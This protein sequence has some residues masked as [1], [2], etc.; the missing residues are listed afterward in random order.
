MTGRE[1]M[2]LA[3][4]L[5][6]GG[7]AMMILRRTETEVALPP[8]FTISPGGEVGGGPGGGGEKPGGGRA[9]MGDLI[10]ATFSEEGG[11]F[12]ASLAILPLENRA[13]LPALDTLAS[14][15]TD[16]LIARLSRTTV[17][18]TVPG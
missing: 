15:M 13:G 10:A 17:T 9:A 6:A 2:L 16:E 11:Q 8:G 14:G 12:D 7:T 18:W 3:A 1:L 4:V 5:A